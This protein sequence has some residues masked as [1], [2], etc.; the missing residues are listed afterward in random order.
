MR[1]MIVGERE[2]FVRNGQRKKK[3]LTTVNNDMKL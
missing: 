1:I 2:I 3:K